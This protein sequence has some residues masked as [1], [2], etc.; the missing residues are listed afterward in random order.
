MDIVDAQ[1]HVGKGGIGAALAA[2]DALGI[3]SVIIDEFWHTRK[4]DHP[5]HIDPGH[6]L[7]NGAWRASWPTAQ[8]AALTHPRRFGFLVRVDRLDPQLE[9]VMRVV[10]SSEGARAFRVQPVWTEEES[11]AFAAGAYDELF[12]IAQELGL[13]VCLFIPGFAEVLRPYARKFPRL[14]FVV[15]HCGMGFGSIPAWQSAEAL[16]AVSDPAYFETVLGLAACPNVALKLSHAQN[17]FGAQKYPYEG[18]IPHLRRA[19]A[20]F[21]AERLLWA[22]D[23]SVIPNHKWGDMLYYLRDSTA[24]S[25]DE[26]AWMLGKAARRIFNFPTE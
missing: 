3:A 5:T 7:P 26:K 23:H 10:A 4:G 12:G 16:R 13:A 9:S 14:N 17:C 21:G 11:V 22:S 19:I 2:M 24:F 15:D 1:I 20:A 8:E 25:H 6:L 18:L